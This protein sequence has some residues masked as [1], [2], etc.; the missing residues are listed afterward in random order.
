[1]RTIKLTLAPGSTDEVISRIKAVDGILG[2]RHQPGASIL[3]PGDRMAIDTTNRA[4]HKVIRALLDCGVAVGPG[5][6][7]MTTTTPL[8]YITPDDASALYTDTSEAT[9]EE[10]E[11]TMA[12]ESNMTVNGMLLMAFS[13]VL[14]VTGIVTDALHIVIGAMIIAPG[15]EPI[16]R[17]ALGAVS[18][19]KSL[20]Y[21]ATS[22]ALAYAS[23]FAGS[24]LA[25]IA[26]RSLGMAGL[27]SEAAYLQKGVLVSYWTSI[28]PPSVLIT[29]IA[30]LAGALLIATN[31]SV[32]TGGVMVALALV[33]T[34]A[35]SGMGLV[36]GRLDLFWSG[37]GRWALEAVIVATAS[38][39]V[40]AWK[41]LR[42]QRR[43]IVL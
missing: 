42:V 41:L 19:G 22:T 14:A 34:I 31:R 20:R 21:G 9:W 23:L 25:T 38:L 3:P 27:G 24:I 17:I 39:A 18:R 36:L 40:F 16:T 8:G 6:G 26:M 32:L 1:M 35:I 30:S 7:S 28:S 12:N 2:I 11:L 5:S 13:G 15:F 4:L 33:P 29:V 43:R 10:M 37:L